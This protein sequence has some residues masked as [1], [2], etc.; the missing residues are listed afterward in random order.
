MENVAVIGASPNQDRYSNKAMR[1]L[2]QYHHTPIPITPKY[3]QIEGKKVYRA[4][5]DIPEKIDTV[6]MYVSPADRR[7]SSKTL[8]NWVPN[9]SFLIQIRKTRPPMIN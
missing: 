1:M 2:A 4:L 5:K 9:G 8:S 3:E 7:P 6:T